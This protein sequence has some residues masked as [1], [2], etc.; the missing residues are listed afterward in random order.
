[1]CVSVSESVKQRGKY[2]NSCTSTSRF[3]TIRWRQ[4][5]GNNFIL[6]K[7][8]NEKIVIF[9]FFSDH[10]INIFCKH[11]SFVNNFVKGDKR[12]RWVILY[13]ILIKF[14]VEILFDTKTQHE[15]VRC[16]TVKNNNSISAD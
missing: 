11:V 9:N 4:K 13:K 10:E 14:F 12:A 3:Q 15:L 5:G 16:T 2:T 8:F 1:M 7:A 6:F